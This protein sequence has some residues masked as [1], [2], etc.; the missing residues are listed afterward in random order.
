MPIQGRFEGDHCAPNRW[1]SLYSNHVERQ[2]VTIDT[3]GDPLTGFTRPESMSQ[4]YGYTSLFRG[5]INAKYASAIG[6]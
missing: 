2:L 1:R 3:Q 6:L 4:I 5:P